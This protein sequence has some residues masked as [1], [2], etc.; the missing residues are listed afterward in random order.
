LPSN[1]KKIVSGG[2]TGADRAALD[3]ARHARLE[4]GGFVPAGRWT[5]DGPIPATYTGLTETESGDPAART[6]LNVVNSDATL[7]FT[8]GPPVGG[9]KLTIAFAKELEKPLL[10]IDLSN[11]DPDK[12]VAEAAE[13]LRSNKIGILNVAG[14]RASEEA[15]IYNE[16]F[17]L[18]RKILSAIG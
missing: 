11:I 9:T 12:A 6:R 14:P 16:T 13:W 2:Q 1:L 7:V 5:E 8:H 4:T 3:A 17:D 10:H 15:D 18:V